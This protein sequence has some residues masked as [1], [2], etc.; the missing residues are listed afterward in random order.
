M[1]S[2]PVLR[3]LFCAGLSIFFLSQ[4]SILAAPQTSPVSGDDVYHKR[5]ASCHDPAG[6]R[7]PTRGALQKFPAKHILRSLDFGGMRAGAGSLN[8]PRREAVAIFLG[9][10]G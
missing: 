3:V 5:C 7:A 6:S 8:A 9:T 1:R 4:I 2:L 10:G